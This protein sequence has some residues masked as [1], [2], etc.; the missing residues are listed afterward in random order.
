MLAANGGPDFA[1]GRSRNSISRPTRRRDTAADQHLVRQL[2]K[3]PDGT[4]RT[5]TR[6]L[7][8]LSAWVI[9]AC[10]LVA[11]ETN[12]LPAPSLSTIL[13]GR[14]VYQKNCVFC[15]GLSGDGRGEMG[16]GV[17][18]R[19]RDFRTGVF[20]FRST[21]SGF[22]PTGEDLTRTI[23][24]GLTGTAMPIF[25]ALREREVQA[26][27]EYVKT[28]SPRWLKAENHA[29]AMKLPTP[30]AW[31]SNAAAR[32]PHVAQGRQLFQ[33]ACAACHGE[34]GDGRGL[35]ALALKD[36]DGEP[37]EPSDL[38]KPLRA[39]SGPEDVYRL[40]VTGMDGTPM[41]SFR[42]SFS[43]AQLWELAA[44]VLELRPAEEGAG[45]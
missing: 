12:A 17:Q 32:Q 25:S 30:P 27:V 37:I 8:V 3:Q 35:A 41:P 2:G 10:G 29:P 18:P 44:Y 23:R 39:G 33:A 26:V 11:G 21:P 15:H 13:Q 20:K 19:P 28:F 14:A 36:S 40:L 38:R 9:G 5:A 16:L 31:L 22:L 43:E 1:N 45:K 24:Q 7:L 42:E 6:R 4:A 34:N